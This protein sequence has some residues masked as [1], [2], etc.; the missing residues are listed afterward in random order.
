M[1]IRSGRASPFRPSEREA[2][3]L[4]V[5]AMNSLP[6]YQDP[7]TRRTFLARTSGGLGAA[8]LAHLFAADTSTAARGVLGSPT[9]VPEAKRVIYLHMSGGPSQ[10]ETFDPKPGLK[11]WDG[12]ALPDSVRGNVRIT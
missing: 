6:E 12:K 10:L 5:D 8:A 11:E 4:P 7:Q 9:L 1:T 2:V 3:P